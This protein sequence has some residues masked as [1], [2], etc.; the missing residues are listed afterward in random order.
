MKRTTFDS[1]SNKPTAGGFTLVELL[2]VISIIALLIAILLPSLQKAREQARSVKCLANLHSQ[3]TAINTYASEHNGALPGPIHP[4]IKRRIFDMTGGAGNVNNQK[5]LTW[6]LRP[7]YG[8]K[9]LDPFQQNE[10]ADKVS[11]CPT[12]EIIVPDAEFFKVSTPSCY[13]E[14]PYSYVCNSWGPTGVS[15][16]AGVSRTQQEW[17]HTDPPHYFGAWFYCDASPIRSSGPQP[18]WYPKQIERI[19]RPADEWAIGDAWYRRI[20]AGAGRPGAVQTRQFIGTFAPQ[21]SSLKPIIPD[22]PYHGIKATTV[23]SHERKNLTVLPRINFKGK[24]NLLFFDGHAS[25]TFGQWITN[26]DGGTINPLWATYGGRLPD[27]TPWDPNG[28]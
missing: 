14:R 24:T 18:S 25:S 6:I 21:T 12:A 2:V 19:K 3:G 7:Y 11:S 15:P 10:M 16:G 22:R 28:F 26:G 23:S 27:N 20:A 17:L 5:S 1:R 9:G 8:G 4:A 13:D